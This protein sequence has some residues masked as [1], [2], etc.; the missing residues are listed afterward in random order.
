MCR[1]T[2]D[3][4]V[5]I[6]AV[7]PHEVKTFLRL[8][9]ALAEYEKMAHLVKNTEE[10]LHKML[11]EDKLIQG[12]LIKVDGVDVG[13]I[14]YYFNYS[15]FEG[16]K[17]LYLEDLY[18]EPAYRKQGIGKKVFEYLASE[19]VRNDCARF[20]WVCL[21]WNTPA[22]NF[23]QKLGAKTLNEWVIHRLDQEALIAVASNH[24]K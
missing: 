8:I 15:S 24:N 23:Y 22:L 2:G 1:I 20:E 16:R 5:S 18:L 12:R 14:I 10:K 11:F 21:D 3:V 7:K 19:A 6:Q 13:F 9:H 17:G 4:M